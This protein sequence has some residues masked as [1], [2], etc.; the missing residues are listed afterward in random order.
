MQ[1]VFCVFCSVEQSHLFSQLLNKVL[2]AGPTFFQYLTAAN[3]PSFLKQIQHLP[4][5]FIEST[6][7]KPSVKKQGEFCM[8]LNMRLKIF[9]HNQL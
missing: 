6:D 7:I 3:L 9:H 5:L 4:S 8:N 1:K 2:A